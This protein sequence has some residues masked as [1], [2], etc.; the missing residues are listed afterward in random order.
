MS[1]RSSR[2]SSPKARAR[3]T[4]AHKVR[5]QAR[6][7]ARLAQLPPLAAPAAPALPAARAGAVPRR[8]ALFAALVACAAVIPREHEARAQFASVRRAP[9]APPAAALNRSDPVTFT[10]DQVVYDRDNGLVTASGHVEAWQNDHVLRADTVTFDRN[11]NVA[12]AHG[13]VAVVEP[14]GQV[15]FSDYAELTEGMREGVLRGMRAIL[16]ENGKL[17]ANGA[18]R[19]EGKINELSRAVY[20]TCDLCARDPTRPP[21]W[22]LRARSA[23][24]DTE[25][26]RIEYRDAVLDIYGVPVAAFPY[27]WHADPSV[28]RASGFLIPS[29]GSTSHLGAFLQ[30]PYY[31]VLDDQSDATISPTF[32]T[33]NGLNLSTQY[34]RRFN[35]GYFSA[36]GGVGWDDGKLGADIFAKGRFAYDDTW[37]YGFDINR[38]TSAT[39]LRDYRVSNRGD[40]LTSQLYLEGFGVGA[41]TRIDSMAYQGLVD[42]IKQSRLPY[43][44]PR[45]EYSFFGQ[46]DPLGGRL[47]FDTINF[48]VVREIG[49]NTQRAGATL[50]WERPF[51]G[52][53]GEKYKLTLQSTMAAYTATSMNQNPNYYSSDSE[54]LVRAHPQAALEV[55]WPLLRDSGRLGTQIIEPIAQ[56]IAGPRT[57]L[58]ARYPNEDSLTFEFTDQNLFALNRFPGI[59]RQEG[60]LRANVGLHAN[61]MLGGMMLDGL[62]GQSFRTSRDDTYPVGSGLDRKRSDYVA[63]ATIA[64]TSWLDFIGRGRFDAERLTPRFADLQA[65][66]GAPIFR[67]SGG[68]IYTATNPYLYYDQPAL[69]ADY[70]VHRNEITLSASSTFDRYRLSGYVRRDLQTGK[71]TSAGFHGT[72]EDECFI[73]DANVSRRSTSLNGDNGSTLVLF[74]ITF[75]TVG[76]FGFHAF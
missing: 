2:S 43:V 26:K 39:Y 49:T 36:D 51:T 42:S 41:Y 8:L 57:G 17:A 33:K 59:D 14:D 22:S 1:G 18:R 54:E 37:R 11:T 73:F 31:L 58:Q 10:A 71:P 46:V 38:A 21:L 65:S 66:V 30:T 64:P 44:L 4:R 24:Q 34:R 50:D 3:K 27:F 15:L 45:H 72:Y 13:H 32:N 20:T 29:F 25:N 74:Q 40:V 12:A 23:L 6:A 48:N 61:W 19:T 70:F 62:V 67:V 76:Q 75:K 35:D 53:A 52:L 56:V 55:R 69:P 5:A 60:G 9:G 68:Y 7:R 47:K 28:K 63:R 16:A